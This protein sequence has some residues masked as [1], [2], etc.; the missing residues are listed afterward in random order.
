M[1]VLPWGAA[2]VLRFLF[3]IAPYQAAIV[4]F[5][6]QLHAAEALT[7]AGAQRLA[8]ERS[9]QVVAQDAAIRASREMAVAAGQL[10]DPTLRGGIDN[11]PI[12][13]PDRFSLS[14]DFMTMRRIGVMQ[15]FTRAE[16]RR[17][18]SE[19]FEREADRAAAD[20]NSAV[21]TIQ[22]DTATAWLDILYLER[23]RSAVAQQA[24]E[25]RREIQAAESAYRGGRGM[26]ADVLMAENSRVMLDDRL[27][28]LGR[29]IRNARTMLARWVGPAAATA[30]LVG[31]PPL[32]AIPIHTHELDQ[33]L[34][35][36]P[37]IAA[38]SQEVAL[39]EA[40]VN[41]ARA[42]KRPDWT[43]EL[44]YQKRGA[45]FSDMV[46]L[47][48]SIPL[49]LFQGNRQ[50]RELAS[51]L[52]MVDKVRAQREDMLRQ[53]VAEVQMML[54]EWENNRERLARY[55]RELFPLARQRTEALASAYRGGKGDLAGVLAARRNEIEVRAQALQLQTDTARVWAQLRYIYPDESVIPAA[56][57]TSRPHRV[58][59]T[60]T[61]ESK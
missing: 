48:V 22:R 40:E 46:S 37:N 56:L 5:S 16:K 47:G 4:L 21:A 61:K 50:D 52:A 39:M 26:Q 14:R 23:L 35:G 53:H 30:E 29:R 34:Q 38:M 25:I 44:M 31:D 10:P 18:R 60:N 17:F 7:L 27:S 57:W 1:S 2:S 36:H 32:H 42:S 13:G 24:E 41:I 3:Q 15:E 45:E 54:N 19:R 58:A 59:P 9:Q 55:E 12:T 20:K 49:Q 6:P 51:R 8:V 28:E 43:W 11:L 33:Q